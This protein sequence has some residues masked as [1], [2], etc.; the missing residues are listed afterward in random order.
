MLRRMEEEGHCKVV[1]VDQ[2]LLKKVPEAVQQMMVL[3]SDAEEP[4]IRPERKRFRL[5][6]ASEQAIFGSPRKVKDN[7]DTRSVT[8]SLE[9][10]RRKLKVR[11]IEVDDS[12][13]TSWE[14]NWLDETES[15]L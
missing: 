13:D 8:C 4:Q 2:V 3:P 11:H 1:P 14:D 10:G 12:S 9:T 6:R 7:R 5:R 15:L